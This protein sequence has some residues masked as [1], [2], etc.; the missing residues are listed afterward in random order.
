VLTSAGADANGVARERVALAAELPPQENV[1]TGRQAAENLLAALPI[2]LVGGDANRGTPP[3]PGRDNPAL[4]L[5]PNSGVELGPVV[6][7]PDGGGPRVAPP[8][9]THPPAVAGLL[10]NWLPV[11]L[12]KLDRAV[13]AL[14]EPGPAAETRGWGVLHWV[15]LS[16]WVAGAAL[17][18]AVARRRRARPAAL[19]ARGLPPEELP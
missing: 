4:I 3:H 7:G 1:L 2:L 10:T 6:E 8:E 17:A 14:I 13:R 5:P 18:F 11:G 12:A 15:G 19:A 16:L 9:P